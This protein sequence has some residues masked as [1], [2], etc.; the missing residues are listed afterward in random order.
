MSVRSVNIGLRR[1]VA[2]ITVLASISRLSRRERLELAMRLYCPRV[3]PLGR[4]AMRAAPALLT[5][6]SCESV[7]PEQPIA[8]II[9]PWS[10]SGI[11]PRDAM[12]PSNASR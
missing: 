6:S 4:Y 11:P 2:D 10:I 5:T 3:L 8:P 9:T 7:P 1:D 12:I